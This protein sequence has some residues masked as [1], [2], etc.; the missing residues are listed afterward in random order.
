MITQTVTSSQSS[1]VRL[2]NPSTLTDILYNL[3]SKADT[4]SQMETGSASLNQVMHPLC[5]VPRQTV[6]QI[7]GP[8]GSG[9][10]SIALDLT[11]DALKK[12]HKVVWLT[13]SDISLPLS[14]LCKSKGFENSL[15]RL[16]SHITVNSLAQL[17][18]LFSN[19]PSHMPPKECGLIVIDDFATLVTLA[20][21]IYN[22]HERKVNIDTILRRKEKALVKVFESIKRLAVK[23]NLAVVINEGMISKYSFTRKKHYLVPVVGYGEWNKYI[24]SR[25]VL[26]KDIVPT[27]EIPVRLR[28][29][30]GYDDNDTTNNKENTNT[31]NNGNTDTNANPHTYNEFDPIQTG[32]HGW[33]R[34]LEAQSECTSVFHA[35]RISSKE[36]GEDP[37]ILRKLAVAMFDITQTGIQDFKK[38]RYERETVDGKGVLKEGPNLGDLS[39]SDNCLE[40]EE[41]EGI[42]NQMGDQIDNRADNQMDDQMDRGIR[43]L[44]PFITSSPRDYSS[45]DTDSSTKAKSRLASGHGELLL[46]TPKRSRSSQESLELTGPGLIRHVGIGSKERKERSGLIRVKKRGL[47]EGLSN[48]G[49]D[50]SHEYDGLEIAASQYSLELDKN[51]SDSS[52]VS[53]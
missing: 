23:H 34:Q 25:V 20:Y 42:G 40:E 35:A 9:K 24:D 51:L 47:S 43:R 11:A 1:T 15:L 3:R 4:S 44:N 45:S 7:S 37:A 18:L 22:I 19:P 33:Y 6:A 52:Q 21:S 29:E 41:D 31:D 48:G 10:T 28:N 8:K 36:N 13:S 27:V 38:H 30:G 49:E 46:P 26:Y 50:L 39:L 2:S 53:E 5:G 17:I 14:R 12:G 16:L 32:G